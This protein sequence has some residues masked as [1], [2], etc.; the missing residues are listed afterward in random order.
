MEIQLQSRVQPAGPAVAVPP[1]PSAGR[2]TKILLGVA[3]GLVLIAVAVFYY[4]R[5]VAPF[6]TTDDAFIDGYVTQIS[7]RV[8]GQ[9]GELRTGDNDRVVQGQV[10]L[11]LDSRDYEVCLAQARADLAVAQSQWD[12]SREQVEVSK[13]RVA[14]AD[15][16]VTAVA[17]Q[18]QHATN[19]LQ[20]YESVESGAVSQSAFD[21]A[22]SQ[23]RAATANLAAAQ[24]QWAAA[25]AEVALSQAMVTTA[26]A[27]VEQAQAKV[28]QAELNLSYTQILAPRDG[29]ITARTVQLGNYVQPGQSLLTVVSAERWVTANFKET[30][31][32]HL[33]PGQPVELRVDA[34]PDR[35]FK[36]R[37]DSV[38]T[39]SGAEF[40]LLPPENAVGNYVK[41]VQ[42]VPVKIV[43]T[44]PL[45]AELNIAPGMSVVPTVRCQ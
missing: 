21:L 20:R 42:R 38:Q 7:S 16:S 6:V 23:A 17:A 12:Q 37:V 26:A 36:G 25:R 34:Y 4:L 8:P 27:G 15:A 41:V 32:T 31:L 10:L 35:V 24:S 2:R 33:R 9:V 40:S 39:G 13:A 28:R 5:F 45:P 29:R 18:N 30:Q 11:A 14:Q 1:P 3:S 19:D 43:F 44:E 22:Q